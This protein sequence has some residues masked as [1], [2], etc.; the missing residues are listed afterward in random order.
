MNYLKTLVIFTILYVGFIQYAN[1]DHAFSH[2]KL[3]VKPDI[4]VLNWNY[5]YKS[6]TGELK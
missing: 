1:T 4:Y 5:M 6:I 2:R 3:L